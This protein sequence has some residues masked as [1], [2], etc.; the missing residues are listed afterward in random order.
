M[1]FKTPFIL[2]LIMGV[3]CLLR[4]IVFV[5]VQGS[6]DTLYAEL[7]NRIANGTF[8]IG[9]D[10]DISGLRTGLIL[11]VALLFKL[12]GP[13]EWTLIAYPF[14]L[15]MGGIIL[16][17]IAGRM[18]FNERAGLLAAALMAIIPVDVR[19]AGILLTDIPSAFFSSVGVLAAYVGAQQES[20]KRK[21]AWAGF[22]GAALGLSWLTRE[23]A[24]YMFPVMGCFLVWAVVHD[25]RN[26]AL[27]LGVALTVVA[28]VAIESIVYWR[29]TGDMLFR[30]HAISQAA[31]KAWNFDPQMFHNLVAVSVPR[32]IF[33]TGPKTILTN[34]QLG[35]VPLVALLAVGYF[36]WTRQK[37]FSLPAFWFLALAG[38]YNFGSTSIHRYSPL[39]LA[40]RYLYILI[41]PAVILVAGWLAVLFNDNVLEQR[42]LTR[43]RRFWGVTL[44]ALLLFK[45]MLP[46]REMLDS[47]RGSQ[48]ERAVSRLIP[49]SAPLYTDWRTPR[50][51]EFFWRFKPATDVHDF[52][53]MRAEEIPP[54]S[55]VLINRTKV[56]SLKGMYSYKPPRFYSEIPKTW[57]NRWHS[58]KG[59]LYLVP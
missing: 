4:M 36:F 29:E 33:V 37:G 52:A 44:V 28:I 31:Q 48:V 13:N 17:F 14:L 16:A 15:S 59:D 23:S 34:Y 35:L 21:F 11:P 22:A 47:G 18:F 32:R 40:N 19:M 55:L 38:F 6:D 7:A 24:V 5:G 39:L 9:A 53:G 51:L 42:H 12:F 45:C 27:L 46:Y 56:E 57:I 43:E 41:F 30:F 2:A 54:G 49:T 8:R 1:K 26:L 3:G 58:D 10:S 25:R 50:V 20:P